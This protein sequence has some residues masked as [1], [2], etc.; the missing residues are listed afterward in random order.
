MSSAIA[1]VCLIGAGILE[2]VW[3]FGLKHSDGFTALGPSIVTLLAMAGSFWLLAAAL[4]II[5]L[6]V[7]YAVWVGI[8][9]VGTAVLG[10]VVLGEPAGFVRIFCILLIVAGIA[11]LK[12]FSSRG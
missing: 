9:T 5:P 3:A 11:G 12:I 10:M 6:G 8:G 4:Q 2:I 1:W 7:G